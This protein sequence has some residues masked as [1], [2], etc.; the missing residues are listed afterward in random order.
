M[1]KTKRIIPVQI[2]EGDDDWPPIGAIDAIAWFQNKINS[3]PNEFQKDATIEFDSVER[4]GSSY[5]TIEISYTRPETEAEI[6]EA[7]HAEEMKKQIIQ[8]EE[9]KTLK[10]LQEKYK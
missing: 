4:Y 10:L 6:I 7:K 5:A 2:E 3:I 1:N 9:L 8:A